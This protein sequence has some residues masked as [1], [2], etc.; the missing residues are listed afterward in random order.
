MEQ[1]FQLYELALSLLILAIFSVVDQS[2]KRVPNA[3]VFSFMALSVV[4]LIIRECLIFQPSLLIPRIVLFILL[5]F[6]GMTGLIGLGDIKLLMTLSLLNDPIRILLAVFIACVL[7]VIYAVVKS[8]RQTINRLQSFLQLFYLTKSAKK[9][10]T[11]RMRIAF[12][13][14]IAIGYVIACIFA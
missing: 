2:T 14:Y 8:P 1:E 6:F 7:V 11:N 5:F 9:S 3:A 12:I 10:T 13:P 4:C